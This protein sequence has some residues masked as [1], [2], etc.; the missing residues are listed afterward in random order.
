MHISEISIRKPVFA[1]ML[2]AGILLFGSISYLQ[3]GVSENPDVDFPFVTATITFEGAAPEVM[4]K[5]VVDPIEGA[6]VSI[7]GIKKITST[8]RNGMANV[9]VEFELNKDIDVA[10]QEVQTAV[11]RAQRFLPKDIDP[12]IVSKA[13]AEDQPILWISVHSSTIPPRELMHIVRNKVKDQ[14][15]VVKG[16]AEIVLG[17]Y[18]DPALRVNLDAQKLRQYQ[19]SVSDITSSIEREHKEEPAGRFE[20]AKIEESV[21]VM[22]EAET[23]EEFNKVMIKRRGGMA[24]YIPM[25]IT[26]VAKVE[27]GLEEVRRVSRA[28]GELAVG[29]GIRKQRGSNSVDVADA[30]KAKIPQIQKMLPEGVH[31]SVIYDSTPFIKETVHELLFTIIMATILTAFV[32]WGFLGS[33]SSTFNVILAIP[34]S[35]IGTFFF[36]NIFGFTLNTISLLGL[37]LAI[38]I[39]VDDAIIVLENIMRHFE[40]G[41]NKVRAALDGSLEITFAVLATTVAL[42]AIFLPVGFLRGIIGKFLFQ[43]A[44][45]LSVAIG[46]SCLEALTLAP[47]R[48]SQFISRHTKRGWLGQKF[49][50]F[51]DWQGKLYNSSLPLALNHPYK[52]LI[53]SAVFFLASIIPLMMIGKEFA[54]EQDES[55]LFVQVKA[56]LGSSME[57]T[58][59]K[60]KLIEDKLAKHP[61]IEKYFLTVGGFQGGESNAGFMFITL[62]DRD[63]RKETQAQVADDIRGYLKEVPELK[64]FIPKSGGGGFGGGRSYAVDFAIRGPDWDELGKLTEQIKDE[65]TKDNSFTD[66]NSTDVTGGPELR[67]IPDRI[68]AQQMGVDIADITNAIRVS[69]GGKT[70]ALYSKDGQRYDVIVQMQES[71]RKDVEQIKNLYVRNN[72]SELV[73][74]SQL[75]KFEKR[76]VPPTITREDR[77][78]SVSITA[79]NAKGVSQQEALNKAQAIAAKLLPSGYQFVLSGSAET[80]KETGQ[81]LVFAL[82]L[83]ILVAYM[84]LASQ[85]NSFLD[86]VLILI[87][88]PFGLSGAFWGL[89]VSSQTLNLYSF[90]GIILLM[91]LV[92]KNAILLVDFGNQMQDEGMN[93]MDAMMHACQQRLR[94]IL[95]T[96]FSVIAAAIP[97]VVNF[98]PGAESR[99]PMSVV[100]VGGMIISTFFTLYAVPALYVLTSQRYRK[101]LHDKKFEDEESSTNLQKGQTDAVAH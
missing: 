49:D 72:R 79:N 99:I 50:Q 25:P 64:G 42:I 54:P 101:K 48:C 41:K 91:G 43:F 57:F 66:I 97:G 83:G 3:L 55:R 8:A 67:V 2:M 44:V 13:N 82:I 76:T 14:F 12:V 98:G 35:I 61:A 9:S 17:G 20:S 23:L 11:A 87:S 16:V 52:T 34:V 38:G 4:E 32:C 73:P 30:V 60:F 7:E 85:F 75:V 63:K 6:I 77:Q 62:K 93:R 94:P 19:L 22:G 78:R 24:N 27:E 59:S 46:I 68:R 53:V 1:W 15:S 80:F 47:M 18:V 90:I 28:M 39:V 86:P 81:S 31:L 58:G 33:W 26:S 51:F 37:S 88:M 56:P 29:V 5:D 36:M 65:M 10:V 96:S 45:T 40:M 70:A 84:I 71:D 21:R 92:K 95:M 74:I 100:V 69:I 89:W